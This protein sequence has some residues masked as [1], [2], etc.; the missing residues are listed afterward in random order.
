MRESAVSAGSRRIFGVTGVEADKAVQLAQAL[1]AR[2]GNLN[3]SSTRA[4]ILALRE[5]A[6][7]LPAV[8]QARIRA[9]CKLF[10]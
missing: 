4:D 2:V 6:F 8:R 5:Q 10:C 1:E 7:V 3:E 9:S